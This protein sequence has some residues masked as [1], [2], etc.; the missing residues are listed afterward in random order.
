MYKNVA[1]CMSFLY[2]SCIKMLQFVKQFLSKLGILLNPS[3]SLS[4]SSLIINCVT[5]VTTHY[6]GL[7]KY[8]HSYKAFLWENRSNEHGRQFS[9]SLTGTY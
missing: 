6:I 7:P 3:C 9:S 1:V 2:F 5:A 4:I 8:I